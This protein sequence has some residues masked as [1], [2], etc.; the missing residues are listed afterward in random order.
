MVDHLTREQRSHNMRA[1]PSRNTVPEILAR[2]AAHRLGFRF[3][4]HRTDLPGSPDFVLP[5]HT[6]AVFVHGCFW[7]G[8]GCRRSKLPQ[9]NVE[10]WESKIGKNR[11]RDRK[12]VVELRKLG[13]RVVTL[14]QC[15]LTDIAATEKR[16]STSV[17]RSKTP[18]RNR[19]KVM[20]RGAGKRTLSL[21]TQEK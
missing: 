8:H 19:P 3:R 13:W 17:L 5:R 1:V 21:E 7:H 4:L 10:F 11:V 12:A 15:Q 9:S 18:G 20:Q 6:V 2:K 14:W 16:I